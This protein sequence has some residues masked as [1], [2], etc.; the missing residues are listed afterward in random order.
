M[1]HHELHPLCSLFPR[2]A[3]ADFDALCA[4]I[5]ANG[6]RHMI[7]MHEGMILDG[8]NRYRAC[9]ETGT[10]PHF[11]DYGHG[12]PVAYVLSQNLH[13]RHLTPGQRAAIVSSA[14][15]WATAQ[16]QGGNGSNQHAPSNSA[17]L[18][19][20]S[21]ADRAVDSGA[22]LR[23]QKMADMVAKADPEL[24]AEVGRGEVSLPA[25]VAQVEAKDPKKANKPK[26]VTPPVATAPERHDEAP[27]PATVVQGEAPAADREEYGASDEEMLTQFND[28]LDEN[29]RLLAIVEADDRLDAAMAQI[30]QMAADIKQK[31]AEIAS[32]RQ[33][34]RGLMNEKNEAIRLCR[35]A[36]ARAARLEKALKD[37]GHGP[38]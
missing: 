18:H 34:S 19:F 22:S 6:L 25:A 9:L 15:N 32:L 27:G 3:D 36:Q 13:R 7:V 30:K 4:D 38:K 16:S 37:M 35:S 5:K 20:S 10:T 33:S 26:K 24:A 1:T 17:I 29:V 31:D 11:T 8:G 14:Q 28:T 23:T 2:M 21:A 12:D